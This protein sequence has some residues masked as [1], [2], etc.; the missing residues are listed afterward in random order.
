MRILKQ[1]LRP[2]DWVPPLNRRF[3]DTTGIS[4]DD[5]VELCAAAE[6]IFRQ[7]PNV[8]HIEVHIVV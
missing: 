1:L 3:A 8:V 4:I 5:I 2:H 6:A 7:E